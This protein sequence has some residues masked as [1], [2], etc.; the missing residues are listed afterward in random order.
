V[1]VVG[2]LLKVQNVDK[3]IFFVN[4]IILHLS[5]IMGLLELHNGNRFCNLLKTLPKSNIP[6]H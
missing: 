4:P 6:F 5:K 1:D 2:H 3:L